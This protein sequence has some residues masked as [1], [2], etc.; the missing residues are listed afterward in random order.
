[1]WKEGGLKQV[2]RD[3]AVEERCGGDI[4]EVEGSDG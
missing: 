4:Q 2:Q 1:M 3:A